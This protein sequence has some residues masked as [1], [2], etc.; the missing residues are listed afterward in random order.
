MQNTT[1]HNPY[2]VGQPKSEE[3]KKVEGAA[4]GMMFKETKDDSFFRSHAVYANCSSCNKAGPTHVDTSC[5]LINCLFAYCCG[6]YWFLYMIH[7]DHDLTCKNA[8]HKCGG[9][10]KNLHNY[11]AC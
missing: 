1:E 11:T 6:G 2:V 5:S 8:V 10:G 3:E 9:C 4:K 7:K